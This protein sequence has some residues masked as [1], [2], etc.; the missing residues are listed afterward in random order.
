MKHILLHL[1]WDPKNTALLTE[2]LYRH[3]KRGEVLFNVGSQKHETFFNIIVPIPSNTQRITTEI[4]KYL[5]NRI[6]EQ[7]KKG[8]SLPEPLLND[9]PLPK[10][11]KTT[12]KN[13]SE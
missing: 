6:M 1:K 8:I 3:V 2:K 12:L 4:T 10:L 7:S 11:N 13:W 5:H 9:Q